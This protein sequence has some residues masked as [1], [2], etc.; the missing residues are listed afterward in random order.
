MSDLGQEL[1]NA[2]DAAS[3]ATVAKEDCGCKE[4][5]TD[6]MM[7]FEDDPVGAL[8]SALD[9]LEQA[10]GSEDLFGG[11]GALF[12]DLDTGKQ[13]TL[14]DVLALAERYPGLRITFSF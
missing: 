11:E 4:M 3:V 5:S 8:N 6:P 7:G 10:P 1:E 13:P 14:E 12:E 9:A 2:L